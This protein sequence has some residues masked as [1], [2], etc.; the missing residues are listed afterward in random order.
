MAKQIYD[1]SV[2][3]KDKSN[4]KLYISAVSLENLSRLFKAILRKNKA[5]LIGNYK[6]G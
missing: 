3:S 6:L 2:S 1:D 4:F 5:E